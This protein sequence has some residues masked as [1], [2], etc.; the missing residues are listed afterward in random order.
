MQLIKRIRQS[1]RL[2]TS[3]PPDLQR[4]A[5]DSYSAS[6]K[7]VFFFAAC[8]TML[9]YLVRLPVR[10]FLPFPSITRP[11]FFFVCIYILFMSRSTFMNRCRL[12]IILLRSLTK[13]SNTVLVRLSRYEMT[14]HRLL[15]PGHPMMSRKITLST[16]RAIKDRM[17]DLLLD[18]HD[19]CL[20]TK[21]AMV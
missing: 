9:S 12:L 3:L 16:T 15:N 18:G 5:R 2:I 8:S 19:D 1:A 11:N 20:R 4:I 10:P 17:G 7:S 6:L 21:M 14:N 13:S